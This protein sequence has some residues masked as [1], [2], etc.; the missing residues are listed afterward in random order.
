MADTRELTLGTTLVT[1]LTLVRPLYSDVVAHKV[2]IDG[3]VCFWK[4]LY[5]AN[6]YTYISKTDDEI[7]WRYNNNTGRTVTIYAK[8]SG[9]SSYTNL[10][11]V[12]SGGSI[13]KTWTGLSGSTAYTTSF[14]FSDGIYKDSE[15]VTSSSITTDSSLPTQTVTPNITDYSHYSNKLHWKVQNLDTQTAT[16]YS[17]HNDTTPDLYVATGIA[18]GA[19]TAEYSPFSLSGQTV[20]A[21]AHDVTNPGRTLSDYDSQYVG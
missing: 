12:A 19:K 2:T 16:I 17:E 21:K 8:R 4:Q 14:Y 3:T 13:Y 15:V 5:S 20:Y 18:S 7:R 6:S 1:G 11:S 9:Q 10:G